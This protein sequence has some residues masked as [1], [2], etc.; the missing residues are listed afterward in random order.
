MDIN[1][2]QWRVQQY[3]A[4]VY[5]LSQQ[6]AS[7]LAPLVRKETF[8]GKAEFFDRLGLATAQAKGARN[9]DT[10]NLNILHSR[11]MVT[12]ST[13]EWATL[14][15]RQ[16]KLATIHMPENEYAVSARNALGRKMDDVLFVAAFGN[17]AAGE[18][19]TTV[20]SL[21]NTKKIASVASAALAKLNLDALRTAKFLFDAAEVEGQR[22]LVVDAD[23]LMALLGDTKV[24]SADYN[25]V[26]ALV[27][28]ELDTYMGFKFIHS[29][30]LPLATT[31]DANTFKFD[32]ATGLYSA[33]G[34][35]VA[36]TDKTCLAFVGDGLIFGTRE[37]MVGKVEQRPDKSYDTQVYASMDF[38]AVRM[39][40]DKVISIMVKA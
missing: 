1:I 6:K 13:Y 31:Y 5:Q 10:P 17:A 26:K 18:D 16:D 35:A 36:G 40:E 8:R 21:P 37:G 19:G 27:N 9:A 38:G 20:V 25:S 24:T 3:A 22:F 34:T 28:G 14:V 39:D 29:E 23:S 7:R 2:E 11:R 32:T 4:N 33:G 15:D 12:A 30:R